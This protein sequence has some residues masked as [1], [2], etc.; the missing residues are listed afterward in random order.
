[1]FACEKDLKI[2]IYINDITVV[3]IKNR[4]ENFNGAKMFHLD[5]VDCCVMKIL[6]G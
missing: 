3:Q 6:L 4:P 1:M 5:N 2:N